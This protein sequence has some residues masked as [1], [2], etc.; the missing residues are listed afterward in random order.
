M[1]FHAW[2][3][4]FY[5]PRRYL[6]LTTCI[7]NLHYEKFQDGTVKCIE[8]E[9]PF[10][11]PEGWEWCRLPIITTDI[12]AGGDKPDICEKRAT[13]ICNIPIYS[14]GIEMMAYMDT[15]ISQG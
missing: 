12:F 13:E 10:E 6:K 11:V 8:D 7:N 4:L 15:L 5:F 2:A 14:N 9:I 3:P 1:E